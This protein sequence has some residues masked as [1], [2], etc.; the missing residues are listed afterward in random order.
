MSPKTQKNTKHKCVSS[1]F[2]SCCFLGCALT[3]PKTVLGLF[4]IQ[5]IEKILGTISAFWRYLSRKFYLNMEQNIA[6]FRLQFEQGQAPVKGVSTTRFVVKVNMK[7]DI[8]PLAYTTVEQNP[9]NPR[10][11]STDLQTGSQGELK[12]QIL[13]LRPWLSA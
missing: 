13:Y 3:E 2:H 6:L 9:Q 1:H 5:L 11:P 12:N 8:I 4:D 10:G 7:Y